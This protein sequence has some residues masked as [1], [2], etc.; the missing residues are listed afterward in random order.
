MCGGLIFIG[1]IPYHKS[2]KKLNQQKSPK[3]GNLRGCDLN[4]Y[5]DEFSHLQAHMDIVNI[6]KR[7]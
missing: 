7:K 6:T 2:S 1:L 4:A 5:I 3:H